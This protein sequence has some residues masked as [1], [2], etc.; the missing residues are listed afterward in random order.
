[1]E[2]KSTNQYAGRLPGREKPEKPSIVPYQAK[3]EG[4]LKAVSEHRVP[5]M[6]GHKDADG[7]IPQ[8]LPWSSAGLQLFM[9]IGVCLILSY[10]YPAHTY[11]LL[12][13]T[14]SFILRQFTA[15][16]LGDH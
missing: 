4:L 13:W 1:M 16:S 9:V 12:S 10:L 7:V 6:V 5:M 8:A 2:E 3:V 11:T 14:P 15:S